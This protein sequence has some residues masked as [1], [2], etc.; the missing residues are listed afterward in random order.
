MLAVFVCT[1]IKSIYDSNTRATTIKPKQNKIYVVCFY[2][3]KMIRLGKGTTIQALT[4]V[5]AIDCFLFNLKF[6][7]TGFVY[8]VDHNKPQG[9][10]EIIYRKN[11]SKEQKISLNKNHRHNP[12]SDVE[13]SSNRMQFKQLIIGTI[14][15]YLLFELH[16]TPRKFD[17]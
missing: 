8:L 2:H 4:F 5:L 1:G 9:L 12:A 16:S 17:V 7:R 13:F 10:K 11:R 6:I 14:P 3:M 15:L